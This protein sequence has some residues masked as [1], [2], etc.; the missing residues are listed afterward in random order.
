M[1]TLNKFKQVLTA[2]FWTL[3]SL[4]L[5]VT[6]IIFVSPAIYRQCIN[7]FN[8]TTIA[9]LSSEDLMRNYH[10]LLDYLTNPFT[11]D[12]LLSHFS[13]SP[14]GLQHF[15][16]VKHLMLANFVMSGVGVLVSGWLWWRIRKQRHHVWLSMSLKLASWL[17]AFLL[18]MVIV[19]FEQLFILFHHVFFRNDLWLFNPLTD[20]IITVLPQELFMLLFVCILLVYELFVSMLKGSIRG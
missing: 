10:A 18:C 5:A 9:G 14:G 15:E 13:S 6:V 12:M 20:P 8:L 7:W 16:E 17:P 11:T 2:I 1:G 4:S 19:A 3:T